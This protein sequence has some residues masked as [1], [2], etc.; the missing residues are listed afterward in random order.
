MTNKIML[1]ILVL[2]TAYG[3]DVRPVTMSQKDFAV[4]VMTDTGTGFLLGREMILDITSANPGLKRS[5]FAVVYDPRTTL[6]VW[7]SNYVFEGDSDKMRF[8]D[9]FASSILTYSGES[10]ISLFWLVS[11]KIVVVDSTKTAKSLDHA[12]EKALGEDR[13]ME[14]EM[15]H[16]IIHPTH[17][18]KER[19]DW[20]RLKFVPFGDLG[21]DFFAPPLSPINGPVRLLDFQ[22][23]DGHF[24]AIV[25]GQWKER[26]VF[27]DDYKVITKT[28]LK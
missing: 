1:I 13:D 18:H 8:S 9:Q 19:A 21:Q 22:R 17:P 3:A 6:Y 25:Q 5:L 7:H 26:I 16:N 28:R 10:R 23:R 4:P 15:D 11:P 20:K 14:T 12:V 27:D 2:S 24:E